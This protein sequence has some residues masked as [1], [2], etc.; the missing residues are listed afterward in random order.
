MTVADSEKV[1]CWN[2]ELL[3]C[4][5]Y[6]RMSTTHIQYDRPENQ[7]VQ[8]YYTNETTH[9]AVVGYILWLLGFFG[10][11]RFYFG[12]RFLGVVYFFTLGFFFIGWI[13]DLFLIPSMAR[14][15]RVRHVPGP[16]DHNIAWLL[17]SCFLLG[18]LGLHRFYLGKWITGVIWLLTLGCLGIGFLYD[19]LTLNEQVDRANLGK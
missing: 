13:I 12:Y 11:H 14:S 15:A 1:P 4:V 7:P 17:H 8:A 2:Q 18:L 16:Y 5:E 6:S 3:T 10:A 9:S 19:W